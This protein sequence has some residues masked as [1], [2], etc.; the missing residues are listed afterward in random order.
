MA[1]TKA[2]APAEW[3]QVHLYRMEKVCRPFYFLFLCRVIAAKQCIRKLLPWPQPDG[4]WRKVTFEQFKKLHQNQKSGT[5]S[6]PANS[7]P[8]NPNSNPTSSSISNRKLPPSAGTLNSPKPA[9]SSRVT[10]PGHPN[11]QQQP[12]SP[13]RAYPDSMDYSQSPTPRL[14][15]SFSPS[16]SPKPMPKT[17]GLLNGGFAQARTSPQTHQG[18]FKPALQQPSATPGLATQLS[19]FPRASWDSPG[20]PRQLTSYPNA[21]PAPRALQHPAGQFGQHLGVSSNANYEELLKRQGTLQTGSPKMQNVPPQGRSPQPSYNART[22]DAA[23]QAILAK[24]RSRQS[25]STN[26]NLPAQQGYS[27]YTST[28]QA[29]PAQPR[30]QQNFYAA[31]NISPHQNA[32]PAQN[33]PQIQRNSWAPESHQ[34]QMISPHQVPP[35]QRLVQSAFSTQRLQSSFQPMPS[36]TPVQ[37][38][39]S[40]QNVVPENWKLS[41]NYLATQSAHG[42]PGQNFGRSSPTTQAPPQ[43]QSHEQIPDAQPPMQRT[44][45]LTEPKFH[46]ELIIPSKSR[47][48][49]WSYEIHGVETD[50]TVSSPN[51]I[52]YMYSP[53]FHKG[54]RF[55]DEEWIVPPTAQAPAASSFRKRSAEEDIQEAPTKKQ[56]VTEENTSPRVAD[57]A[58]VPTVPEPAPALNDS[59]SPRARE[60]APLPQPAVIPESPSLNAQPVVQNPLPTPASPNM[61]AK[62]VAQ[63]PSPVPALTPSE[64]TP[65]NVPSPIASTT[66]A[67][68]GSSVIAAADYKYN[69]NYNYDGPSRG[70][71]D[72]SYEQVQQVQIDET[73]MAW[74]EFLH[75]GAVHNDVV[76]NDE[77][78]LDESYIFPDW[79]DL[80][81]TFSMDTEEKGEG[82]NQEEVENDNEKEAKCS[83][84]NPCGQCE[85]CNEAEPEEN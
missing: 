23:I 8:K 81:D 33:N 25:T 68:T 43:L 26:N 30:Y 62:P 10:L 16:P 34:P 14:K 53:E 37:P 59:I 84:W 32:L 41:P 61:N 24:Q 49:K 50:Y 47:G 55:E 36:S 58:P 52:M 28:N 13:P 4:S 75:S 54:F 17:N 83:F 15:L 20:I 6:P 65:G 9:G 48:W 11:Y 45:Y 79:A 71:V 67:A 85:N 69:S 76:H 5:S 1:T 73:V 77:P 40:S 56:K 2:C 18:N 64:S 70:P 72:V 82:N 35:N 29:T 38:P 80:P 3:G 12:R 78:N 74:D 57:V 46:Q 21:P 19:G 66:P 42:H 44:V 31:Q 22:Q 51:V 7:S 39:P 27:H 63:N 60:S